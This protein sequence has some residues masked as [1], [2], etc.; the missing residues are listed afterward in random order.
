MNIETLLNREELIFSQNFKRTDVKK[1][2]SLL[3]IIFLSKSKYNKLPDKKLKLR[4]K[5]NIRIDKQ[6]VKND[7]DFV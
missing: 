3:E 4:N 5:Q 6:Y 2:L 1:N 7:C